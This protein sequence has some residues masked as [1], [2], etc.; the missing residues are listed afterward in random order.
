VKISVSSPHVSKGSALKD[1]TLNLV[2]FWTSE[3]IIA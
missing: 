2:R 3:R 1:K